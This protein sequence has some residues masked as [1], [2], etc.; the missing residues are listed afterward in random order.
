MRWHLK[1]FTQCLGL[2]KSQ[3]IRIDLKVSG[4]SVIT[5]FSHYYVLQNF[6]VRNTKT[7]ILSFYSLKEIILHRFE[8]T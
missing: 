2:Y 6:D 8:I 7:F 3:E 1:V 5:D 4:E